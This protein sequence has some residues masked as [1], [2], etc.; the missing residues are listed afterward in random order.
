MAGRT[1][2]N[3]SATQTVSPLRHAQ[4]AIPA[5]LEQVYEDLDQQSVDGQPGV[6][7]R[8]CCPW[9]LGEHSTS[10]RYRKTL[11]EYYEQPPGRPPVRCPRA[12]VRYYRARFG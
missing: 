1:R 8:A 9:E 12:T 6:S 5:T 10:I 4:L 7:P 2:A 11:G 3:T